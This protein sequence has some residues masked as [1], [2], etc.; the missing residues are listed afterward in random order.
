[1]G[2]KRFISMS[3]I[4]QHG[5]FLVVRCKRCRHEAEIREFGERRRLTIPDYTSRLRCSKCGSRRV[6][7]FGVPEDMR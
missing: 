1:M 4:R 3:D 5:C 6:L 7:W 2:A